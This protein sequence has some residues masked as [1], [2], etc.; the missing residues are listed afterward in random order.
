MTT[1]LEDT[2]GL[3]LQLR[4]ERSAPTASCLHDQG[5]VLNTS[6]NTS[7]TPAVSPSGAAS[8]VQVDLIPRTLRVCTHASALMMRAEVDCASFICP[9]YSRPPF[10]PASAAVA[11]D[12]CSKPKR[13]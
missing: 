12:V 9:L 1:R 11:F 2:G 7:L 10:A 5:R 3:T 8:L 4:A 6:G 13:R